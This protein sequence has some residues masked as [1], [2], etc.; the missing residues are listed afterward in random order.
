MTDNEKM[1]TAALSECIN[2]IETNRANAQ[3]RGDRMRNEEVNMTSATLLLARKAIANI[4][5]LVACP[6]CGADLSR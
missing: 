4:N 1:L 5:P 2:R 6:D 3:Q